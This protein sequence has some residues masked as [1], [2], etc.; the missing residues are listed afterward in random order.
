[1]S[2]GV[3][4]FIADLCARGLCVSVGVSVGVYVC[5]FVVPG[6]VFTC[7]PLCL[8]PVCRSKS[9]AGGVSKYAV[10]LQSCCMLERSV[11]GGSGYIYTEW[12]SVST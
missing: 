5:V 12:E 11:C 9:V 4:N 8:S 6:F 1:M 7:A 3:A 10:S 2:E